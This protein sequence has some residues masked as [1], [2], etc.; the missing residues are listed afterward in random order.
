MNNDNEEQQL[1]AAENNEMSYFDRVVFEAGGTAD[2]VEIRDGNAEDDSSIWSE[3]KDSDAAG[4]TSD[5]E[6]EYDSDD[7]IQN[8]VQIITHSMQNSESNTTSEVDLSE[9]SKQLLL[10]RLDKDVS[11]SDW[12]IE[13]SIANK[14]NRKKTYHVHKTTLGLGPKKSGYFETLL[15]LD[16]SVNLPIVQVW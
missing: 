1:A 6:M 7:S 8:S 3:T 10:W 12:T 16:N 15:H 13:V 4:E 11:F 14:R 2:N 9:E 5:E